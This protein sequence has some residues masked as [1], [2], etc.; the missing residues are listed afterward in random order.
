MVAIGAIEMAFAHAAVLETDGQI[1]TDMG[2][3]DRASQRAL[4][5][6]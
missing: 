1:R 2:R 3:F 4:S 6:R 5:F